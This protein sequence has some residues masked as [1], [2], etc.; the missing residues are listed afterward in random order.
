MLKVCIAD[1]HLLILN[2]VRAAL[3]KAG[4]IEVVGAAHSGREVLSLI[5]QHVPDLVLLDHRMPDVDGMS[6]LR[7]IKERWPQ[8]QVVMLSAS[9]D[10]KQIAEALDAG[11]SAYIGKRINPEDLASALRQVVAGV[12]YQR[13]AD[14]AEEVASA[15][16]PSPGD[17][18]TKSERTMLDAVARGLSTKAISRELWISEK[19]VKFHL[20]NIYRKL[21]VHN[22]TG[23]MRYAF[24][25]GLVSAPSS[26]DDDADVASA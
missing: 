22:R 6:C 9:E 7:T 13:S 1:D 17:E 15:D 10:P 19:T 2:A 18:L 11:A 12:V 25:H 24:E 8:V 20:T 21:G 26:I 23:A 5:E 3:T 14:A 16:A 4:D